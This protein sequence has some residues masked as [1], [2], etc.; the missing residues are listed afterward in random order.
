M[1]LN[2]RDEDFY[3]QYQNEKIN[4]DVKSQFLNNRY[5][6]VNINQKSH[7]RFTELLDDGTLELL[8]EVYQDY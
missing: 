1:F 7:K 5:Q 3:I 6:S 8:E 4:F 2:K